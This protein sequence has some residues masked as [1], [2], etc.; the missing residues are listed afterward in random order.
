[1]QQKS[2]NERTTPAAKMRAGEYPNSRVLEFS[3]GVISK[4]TRASAPSMAARSKLILTISEIFGRRKLFR[5]GALTSLIWIFS[6]TYTPIQEGPSTFLT[7]IV[8]I[9]VLLF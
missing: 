1:M 3:E 6:I 2:T 9:T 8:N 4:A 5:I 7:T